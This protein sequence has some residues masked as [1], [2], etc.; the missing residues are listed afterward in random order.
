MSRS[1]YRLR[2]RTGLSRTSCAPRSV[3]SFNLGATKSKVLK[4]LDD[5]MPALFRKFYN[6]QLFDRLLQV[7]APWA[8]IQPPVR[9]SQPSPALLTDVPDTQP[10][11]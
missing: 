5:S 1:S 10:R 6:S 7:R 11:L 9:C 3:R 8:H 4:L 2:P